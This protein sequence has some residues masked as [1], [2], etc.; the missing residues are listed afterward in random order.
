LDYFFNEN[1]NSIKS[2][3]DDRK[4]KLPYKYNANLVLTIKAAP[5]EDVYIA[6]WLKFVI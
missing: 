4:D 2:A 5:I 6:A 3:G 1:G